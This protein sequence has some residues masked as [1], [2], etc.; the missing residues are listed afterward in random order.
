MEVA[1]CILRF[2]DAAW[3]FKFQ[4]NSPVLGISN[5]SDLAGPFRHGMQERMIVT[6]YSL[7]S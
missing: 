4:L 7:E 5:T 3:V 1:W 6:V 2:Y